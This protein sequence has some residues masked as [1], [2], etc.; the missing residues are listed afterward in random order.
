MWLFN[1]RILCFSVDG[2]IFV[3]LCSQNLNSNLDAVISFT[4]TRWSDNVGL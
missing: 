4:G 1:Y 2:H 3:S